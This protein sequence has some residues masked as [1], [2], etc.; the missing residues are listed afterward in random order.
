LKIIIGWGIMG[1]EYIPRLDRIPEEIK[2]ALQNGTAEMI[3][4]KDSKDAFFLQIRTTVKGLIISGR[5][6]GKNKEAD[7]LNMAL[8]TSG[9]V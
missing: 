2:Q 1:T 5:E 8:F 7:V 9:T 3:P 4:C 6:Y